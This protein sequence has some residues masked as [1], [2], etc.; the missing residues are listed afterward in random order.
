MEVILGSAGGWGG[1]VSSFLIG[2][3]SRSWVGR[4]SLFSGVTRTFL[5]D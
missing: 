1:L 5:I 3:K 2:S 4:C